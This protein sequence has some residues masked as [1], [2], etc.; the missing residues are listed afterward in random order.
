MLPH[1]HGGKGWVSPAI[2]AI[3]ERGELRLDKDETKVLKKQIHRWLEGQ[4]DDA[5]LRELW[6]QDGVLENLNCC[7]RGVVPSS[8]VP[9]IVPG[10]A[11]ER[12]GLPRMATFPVWEGIMRGMGVRPAEFAETR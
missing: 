3:N 4:I 9:P 8:T 11:H 5:R 10:T 7:P 6:Q 12:V 2:L 1:G